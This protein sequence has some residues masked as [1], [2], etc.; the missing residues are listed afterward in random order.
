MLDL[1]LSSYQLEA[2]E[3][4]SFMKDTD[5]DMRAFKKDEL[6]ASDILNSYKKDELSEIFKKYGEIGN[7]E[8]LS[9]AIAEKRRVKKIQND[10]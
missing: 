1:G 2:E 3:G 9:K 4:F 6:T 7:A 8:R 5:L 10:I